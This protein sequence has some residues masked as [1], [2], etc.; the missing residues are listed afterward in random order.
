[1]SKRQIII[2]WLILGAILVYKSKVDG[3]DWVKASGEIIMELMKGGQD[4]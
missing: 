2:L 1:M 3:S 4:E